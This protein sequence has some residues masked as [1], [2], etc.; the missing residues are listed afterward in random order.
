MSIQNDL[1]E[2][3]RQDLGTATRVLQK[4]TV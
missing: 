4:E 3:L 1:E 2:Q